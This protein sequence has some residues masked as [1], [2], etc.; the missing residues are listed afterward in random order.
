MNLNITTIITAC[1]SATATLIVCL[2]NNKTTVEKITQEYKNEV[3]KLLAQHQQEI[4]LIQYQ[5]TELK[6]EVKTNNEV[7][8]RT[9]KLE[10]MAMLFDEKLDNI[11]KRLDHVEDIR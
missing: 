6:E 1:I 5:L 9:S 8:V 7:K 11:C 2:I 4:A 10:G 3:N